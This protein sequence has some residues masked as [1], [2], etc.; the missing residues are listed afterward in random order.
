MAIE[1][2]KKFLVDADAFRDVLNQ[3]VHGE[4]PDGMTLLATK[5]L[6]QAYIARS[7]KWVLRVRITQ[8]STAELCVK[9]RAS[10]ESRLEFEY[11]TPLAEALAM[12]NSVDDR[13]SKTRYVIVQ[14]RLTWEVDVFADLN[15]GLVVAELEGEDLVI[16]ELPSFV[17]QEVTDD[18]R[19]YNDQ[20]T[21]RPF[22]TWTE[23]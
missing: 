2:E 1:T 9:E 13:I 20:L 18:I 3:L 16:D 8:G 10:G 6:Q 14:N 23:S 21:K 15:D 11:P 17:R 22:T 7:E 12:F 4:S 19:Y 5:K